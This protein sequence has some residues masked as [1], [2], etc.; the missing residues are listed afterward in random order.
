MIQA[1]DNLYPS[2]RRWLPVCALATAI[3]CSSGCRT[4]SIDFARN[5]AGVASVVNRNAI[6][7]R[8]IRRVN[9]LGPVRRL[10]AESPPPSERTKQLLRRYVLEDQY[11]LDPDEAIRRMQAY[12]LAEPGL[13][14]T[15]A[16]AELAF[17]QG[18][19]SARLGQS[20]R[21]SRM[22]ATALE[23][24]YRFLFD[25]DL[26]IGRNAYD[27]QFRSIS[28][29]YNRSLEAIL[30]RLIRD[31]KL[32]PGSMV[33]LET[34]NNQIDFVIEVPGRWSGEA[35]EKFE[36]VNDFRVQGVENQYRTYGLGVPLIGVRKSRDAS[37]AFEE[38][39]PPQLTMALTAFLELASSP[40]RDPYA[41]SLEDSDAIVAKLSLI[42][43][44]EQTIAQVGQRMVPL[45]S[46]I[47]TPMARYLN[48]PL[49]NTNVFATLA[50]LNADFAN[51]FEGLYMLEPYDPAK[52]P[53]VMIHGLWSSPVTWLQMFN[54]L[55]ADRE[56]RERYQFW[57]CL[58]PTGQP[59]WESARQV[60]NQLADI[61]QKLTNGQGSDDP[62]LP[63]NQTILVGHSMG[64]LVARMQTIDSE[65]LFWNVIS[66]HE[67][68][69]FAGSAETIQRLE[70]TFRFQA[71]PGI[72]QVITLATPL[73][74]S[75]YAN[76]TTRWL[77]R[78]AITLPQ[79][80]TGEYAL[81]TARNRNLIANPGPLTVATSVDSLS[82]G[83]PFFERLLQA[84]SGRDVS[85][86]N[87][88][89]SYNQNTIPERLGW[90]KPGDGVVET[91]SARADDAVSEIEIQSPHNTIHQNPLAILEVKRILLEHL[92]DNNR[93]QPDTLVRP[94]SAEMLQP[95]EANR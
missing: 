36:L 87:I 42:D 40:S 15:H 47:T 58:Y 1:F 34:I 85:Y 23:S 62:S 46:D 64:G 86:H 39:Y 92:V 10:F 44:L 73:R 45:E 43:P 82:S 68:S 4:I 33:S 61:R 25:P 51:D 18:E 5:V 19:W 12:A 3:L 7:T 24:S 30:R 70:E 65:D 93:T 89:G 11:L 26:D 60:R 95:L 6:G 52:I 35:F 78:K 48:D 21:A 91:S 53:V 71:N 84:R 50:L 31:D 75:T 29:I 59:W 20:N 67:P 49:L 94:V 28:D 88:Y 63:I 2:L 54:D 9:N 32:V 55:R 17:K 79:A 57:F 16:V 77:G 69:E 80:F 90:V 22:Y 8:P 66:E 81:I 14:R 38:F 74:G 13:E 41:T 56:I 27:P 37:V 76:E 72:R 83:N